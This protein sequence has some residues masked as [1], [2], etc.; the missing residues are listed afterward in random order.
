MSWMGCWDFKGLFNLK[1]WAVFGWVGDVEWNDSCQ[2]M[3]SCV[4]MA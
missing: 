3:G 1:N 4:L 2:M